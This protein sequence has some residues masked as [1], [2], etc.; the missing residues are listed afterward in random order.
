MIP[1]PL[2]IQDQLGEAGYRNHFMFKSGKMMCLHSGKSYPA[3]ELSVQAVYRFEENSDPDDDSVL[4]VLKA[5][6]GTGGVF[7][8]AHGVYGDPEAAA[9]ISHA[10]NKRPQSDLIQRL[11]ATK[12][13]QISV[14][15]TEKD[16]DRSGP[17]A[18]S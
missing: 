12:T 10:K 14:S 18:P 13:F 15:V 9:F 5:R 7:F 6:D 16:E 4:W 3:D 2:Q 1:V 17:R 8:D 11:P